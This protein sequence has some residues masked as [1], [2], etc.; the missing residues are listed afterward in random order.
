MDQSDYILMLNEGRTGSTWLSAC[1]GRH[2]QVVDGCECNLFTVTGKCSTGPGRCSLGTIYNRWKEGASSSFS[3]SL[4]PLPLTALNEDQVLRLVGDTV[5]RMTEQA[6]QN[7]RIDGDFK[8]EEKTRLVDKSPSYLWRRGTIECLAGA[9]PNATR[10]RLVRD[11]RSVYVSYLTKMPDFLQTI[12]D[13]SGVEG[14]CKA[15][16]LVQEDLDRVFPDLPV[17]RY[18]DIRDNF[19]T[20]MTTLMRLLSLDETD[21]A[22]LVVPGQTNHADSDNWRRFLS[23]RDI[24]IFDH[25]LHDILERYGY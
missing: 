8:P 13:E 1:L 10:F 21:P 3:R 19:D 17:V 14:F 16:R 23:R 25:E 24:E 9:L 18:E 22:L 7:I 12:E 20:T 5:L 15:V 11:L 2:P 6:L 4:L